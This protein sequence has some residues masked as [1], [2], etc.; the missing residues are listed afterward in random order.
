MIVEIEHGSGFCF[1]VQRAIEKAEQCLTASNTLYCLG[2]IV[3]NEVEVDRLK[4]LGLKVINKNEFNSVLNSKMLIRAH[5]EPPSTYLM[6]QQQQIEIID[7]TCPIVLQLQN[8]IK[9]GYEQMQQLNGSI[10]IYGKPGHAEVIGLEGQTNNSAI[11]INSEQDINKIDTSRPIR[12]YSQTTQDP[13][14]YNHLAKLI[15][16]KMIKSQCTEIIDFIYY[17]TICRQVSNR[18]AQLQTFVKRFDLILFVCS[19]NSSNGMILYNTCKHYNSNTVRISSE[20]DIHPVMLKGINSVGICGAT[21]TP[22]WLMEKVRA[23]LLSY[24]P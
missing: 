17:D 23:E 21:S 7:A 18:S 13:T 6:A 4:E 14:I 16:D 5:G 1:G 22:L 9:S 24:E 2:E 12:L 19:P 15:R 11:V 10:V 20:T 3:H 8:K